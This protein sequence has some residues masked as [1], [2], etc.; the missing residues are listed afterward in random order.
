MKNMKKRKKIFETVLPLYN[1]PSTPRM[2]ILFSIISSMRRT[3]PYRPL[4]TGDTGIGKTSFIKQLSKLLGLSEI[5]IEV[6]HLTE[7][8]V[9]Q[10]PFIIFSNN[11]Q[12]ASKLDIDTNDPHIQLATSHLAGVLKSLR[13]ISDDEYLRSVSSFTP[14]L[15]TMYKELGGSEN[16]IPRIISDIRR[17]WHGILFLDEYWRTTTQQVRNILRGILDSKIGDDPL[18]KGIYVVYASNIQDVGGTIEH[19]DLNAVQR[20]LELPSPTK[21][22][23]ISF[24]TGKYYN[25]IHPEIIEA[26][27]VALDDEHISSKDVQTEIRTSPRRWEQILLYL[28]ANLPVNDTLHAKQVLTN[29]KSMFSNEHGETSELHKIVDMVVRELIGEEH[30]DEKTLKDT[31]W[32]LTLQNQIETKMKLGD[33]RTYVPVVSGPPGIGKTS[34]MAKIA[35]NLNLILITVNAQTLSPESMMGI[36]LPKKSE[37]SEAEKFN[38]GFSPSALYQSIMNQVEE[39][40]NQFLNDPHIDPARIKKWKTQ[41]YKYLLFIDEF[42]RVSNP[43]VFNSLR[44]VILDKK[45]DDTHKIPSDMI[46]SAAINPAN[47]QNKNVQE[48]TGH[49]K[50]A[51]DIINSAPSWNT[52][53][54]YLTDYTD[55]D[56]DLETVSKSIRDSAKKFIIEFSDNYGNKLSNNKI[57][58]DSRKFYIRVTDMDDAYISPRDYIDLYV[59]LVGKIEVAVDYNHNPLDGIMDAFDET[60]KNVLTRNDIDSPQ[61]ISNVHSWIESVYENLM[62]KERAR[63]N[64]GEILDLCLSDK[65]HHLADDPDFHNYV[66]NYE[67]N[68]FTEDLMNYI[69]VLVGREKNAYDLWAKNQVNQKILKDGK[70]HVINDLVSK[71]KAIHDEVYHAS[72]ILN[73]SNDMQDAFN[74]AMREAV[75][76]LIETVDLPEPPPYPVITDNMTDEQKEEVRKKQ[77]ELEPEHDAWHNMLN[78]WLGLFHTFRW[79]QEA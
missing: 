21:D 25:I 41:P 75:I 34:E 38:V 31:E 15:M 40:T 55:K 3:G 60:L 23:F 77:E 13:P 48:I 56:Q 47:D 76:N 54:S 57:S 62:K 36:P 69:N 71:L 39:K 9:I 1:A 43:K 79:T 30:S 70:V 11:K 18:P 10:I 5:L 27:R 14:D 32:R 74:Q 20:E 16:Q 65:N 28:N 63:S 35:H 64:L 33:S 19:R 17:R 49:M 67:K 68:V 7:E 45:F 78:D 66:G 51:I 44:M 59:N 61:F 37:I 12:T 50:D 58:D 52:F 53:I 42:N 8:H 26:F 4:L 24:I 22:E 46:I 29:I 73:I 2:K 6:P 72:D